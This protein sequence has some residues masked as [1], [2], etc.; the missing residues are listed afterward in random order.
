[1][2]LGQTELRTLAQNCKH[3]IPTLRTRWLVFPETESGTGTAGTVF[4]GT[5][6]GTVLCSSTALKHR[7][8]LFGEDRRN[9]KPELLDSTPKP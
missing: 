2:V 4:L 5:E 3:T 7:K 6:T 1:M 8:T 9:R